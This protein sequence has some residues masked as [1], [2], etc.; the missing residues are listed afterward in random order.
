MFA[1][2][3]SPTRMF[4]SEDSM[5]ISVGL[6][7]GAGEIADSV[8]RGVAKPD[9]SRLALACGPQSSCLDSRDQVQRQQGNETA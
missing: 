4:P 5:T 7:R 9:L 2:R 6:Y 1:I 8:F 3:V